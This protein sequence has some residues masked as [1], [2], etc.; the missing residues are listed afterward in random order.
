VAVAGEARLVP[1]IFAGS[2]LTNALLFAPPLYVTAMEGTGLGL[3]IARGLVG[4]HGGTIRLESE[5]GRGSTAIVTLPAD[6]L[7]DLAGPAVAEFA[8]AAE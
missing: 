4:L 5:V 3:S 6:R 7:V 2:L 8:E 1:G